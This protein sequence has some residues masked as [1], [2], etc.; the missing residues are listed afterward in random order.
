MLVNWLPQRFNLVSAL[1]RPRCNWR[2]LILTAKRERSLSYY[3]YSFRRLVSGAF[4]TGFIGSTYTASPISGG[5]LDSRL[6][7]RSN[8]FSAVRPFI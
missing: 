6:L 1:S 8:D 5:M 7:R 2:K 4:N 3:S